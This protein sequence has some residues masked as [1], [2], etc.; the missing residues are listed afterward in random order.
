[1][2]FVLS[3]FVPHLSFFLMSRKVALCEC[4]ISWLT[5][6]IFINS[7]CYMAK[8]AIF[9]KAQG[10]MGIRVSD[11]FFDYMSIVMAKI[12]GSFGKS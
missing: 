1:M 2:K 11:C 9:Y 8:T 3:L 6:L 4:G 5:I 12:R 7:N 10:E